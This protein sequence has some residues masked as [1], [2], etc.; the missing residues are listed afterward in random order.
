MRTIASIVL[1]GSL[2]AF[3]GCTNSESGGPGATKPKDAL[4]AIT[5]NDSN[6]FT[7]KEALT[8]FDI[9]QGETKDLDIKIERK[10]DF[11]Q[12]VKVKIDTPEGIKADPKEFEIKASDTEMKVKITAD[13]K[14]PTGDEKLTITG[15]PAESGKPT[16]YQQTVKIE[17]K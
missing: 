15:T 14:A 13:D 16:N 17:K 7:F 12:G 6:T 11:K 9:K 10:K 3:V 4:G 8:K 5:P 1:V 2:V